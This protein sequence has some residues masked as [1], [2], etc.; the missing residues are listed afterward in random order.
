MLDGKLLWGG[1][2]DLTADDLLRRRQP[3]DGEARSAADALIAELQGRAKNDPIP[4]KLANE[5]AKLRG[6]PERT[7]RQ[8]AHRAKL[9]PFRQGYGKGGG[10][11][12]AGVQH[13]LQHDSDE[14]ATAPIPATDPI[15]SDVAGMAGMEKSLDILHSGNSHADIRLPEWEKSKDSSIPAIPATSLATGAAAGMDSDTNGDH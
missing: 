14:P 10:W 2:V 8:A 15:P 11:F 12:W 6:I 4:V 3:G 13:D 5:A 1:S 7:L 9:L